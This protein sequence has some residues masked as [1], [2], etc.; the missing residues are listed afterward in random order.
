MKLDIRFVSSQDLV[1][2][3]YASDSFTC[4]FVYGATDKKERSIMLSK[5]ETIGATVIGLWIVLGDFNYIANLNERIG[6][7]SRLHEI[8]PLRRCMVNCDIHDMKSTGRFFTWSNKQR[9]NA[10]VLSKI[11]RELENSAW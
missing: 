1:V 5:L 7:K 2:S 11:N 8:E 3:P 9:G 10:R 6:Q 4:S